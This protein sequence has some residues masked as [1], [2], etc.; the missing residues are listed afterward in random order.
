MSLEAAVAAAKIETR[1]YAKRQQTWLK[2]NMIAWKMINTQETERID[3]K[4]FPFSEH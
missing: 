1:Q 3:A 4:I 2:R